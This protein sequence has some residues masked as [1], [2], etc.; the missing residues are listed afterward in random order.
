[1]KYIVILAFLACAFFFFCCFYFSDDSCLPHKR[2]L[3]K[4]L[5]EI[6]YYQRKHGYYDVG[7]D[8]KGKLFNV[9]VEYTEVNFYYSQYTVY[10]NGNLVKTFHILEHIFSKSRAEQH[11][12]DM[13]S[14]EED[15]I[16]QAAYKFCKKENN[17]NFN[18]KWDKSSY[19]N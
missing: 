5:D 17:K 15:E 9:Y 7:F 16:I 14:Y 3:E 2:K 4:M 10:I 6:R 1:M 13:R 11:H 18:E 8:Y 12:G 19:F